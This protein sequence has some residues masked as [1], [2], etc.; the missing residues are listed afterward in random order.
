MRKPRPELALHMGGV[1]TPREGYV[2]QHT[3][4]RHL[5]NRHGERSEQGAAGPAAG[6][7]K[8]SRQTEPA[9]ALER[10]TSC[11]SPA[12]GDQ[13]ITPGKRAALARDSSAR[14]RALAVLDREESNRA[15]SIRR[16]QAKKAGESAQRR[17]YQLAGLLDRVKTCG[18]RPVFGGGV[19]AV[20]GS[21]RGARMLG[22]CRCESR[23][24]PDCA[25]Q[26]MAANAQINRQ[27][28]EWA[29]EQGHDFGMVTLTARH[30]TNSA[31]DAAGGDR[32]VALREQDLRE[33][34]D[35]LTRA[36]AKMTSG[37]A[38]VK[39]R[40][41]WVGYARAF[42]L[43]ADDLLSRTRVTGVHGHF[44]VA[45]IT[46]AGTFDSVARNLIERWIASCKALDLEADSG[47]QKAEA[48]K[49]TRWLA[50]YVSKGERPGSGAKQLAD[51]TSRS[52]TKTENE[53]GRTSPEGLLRALGSSKIETVSSSTRRRLIA[54]WV[55]IEKACQ[56]RR[57]LTWSRGL[58]DLAGAMEEPDEEETSTDQ[59][60]V[61]VGVEEE[62][63]PHMAALDVAAMEAEPDSR[64]EVMSALLNDENVR[65]RVL[66][67]AD[68]RYMRANLPRAYEDDDDQRGG[69]ALI[70][71]GLELVRENAHAE[72]LSAFNG[73]ETS[74]EQAELDL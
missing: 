56:G 14:C 55:E 59:A 38:G 66:L 34:F 32:R 22:L 37:K 43:T 19:V 57:W 50:D 65:H 72:A 31:L 40:K 16:T 64:T 8:R 11:S 74:G 68:W 21:A 28:L 41:S 24:C 67:L 35:R 27:I 63:S 60:T 54:Q 48:A 46:P 1:E 39:L 4:D 61:I 33:L 17:G 44:H 12:P 36:W 29:A 70:R 5:R 53:S 23:W 62:L 73:N 25:S 42:E 49:S 7:A 52:D 20:A 47:G 51:E 2:H 71:G 26:K 45:L 18:E 6:I 10:P 30:F 3:A 9:S 58:K 15:A 69:H 13:R